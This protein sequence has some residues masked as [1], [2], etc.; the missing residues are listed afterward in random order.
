MTN[1][2]ESGYIDCQDCQMLSMCRPVSV[3]GTDFDLIGRIR[4]RRKPVK[5]GEVLFR[6]GQSFASIYALCAGSI[7]I[8]SQADLDRSRVVG[9]HFPGELVGAGDIY[10]DR[11]CCTAQALED[12]SVCVIPFGPLAHYADLVPAIQREIVSLMSE[13][14]AHEQRLLTL[15]MGRKTAAER[16][17]VFLVS[18]AIRFHVRG[19]S[20]MA[21]K[22]S[23]KRSDIGSYLGLTKETVSRQLVTFQ[24]QGLIAMRQRQLRIL[25][26]EGLHALAD[27]PAEARIPG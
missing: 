22:L 9:F 20:T 15:F 17:A 7:K 21:F 12:I 1:Q 14:L 5:Q 27:T 6:Q 23:M 13:Q 24:K 3:G 8:T 10:A 25:D 11:H 2:P 26:I 19:Q 4:E 16:V 18:L